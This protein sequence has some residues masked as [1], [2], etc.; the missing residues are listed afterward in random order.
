AREL[1]RCS[2]VLHE[3][4]TPE[5]ARA[6]LATVAAAATEPAV[7]AVTAS[8]AVASMTAASSVAA[9]AAV[10][11]AAARRAL[12]VAAAPTIAAVAAAAAV[13]SRAALSAIAAGAASSAD[14][15][16]GELLAS[17]Q[18]VIL[19]LV[20]I[21]MSVSDV[22]V[23]RRDLEEDQLLIGIELGVDGT[24]HDIEH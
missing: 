15:C 22:E 20:P 8:R 23:R 19:F 14:R 24:D 17:M 6:D 16:D 12:S 21:R 1:D 11:A 10:A 4:D 9:I 18:D 5:E 2:N 7:A 3:T 13:A